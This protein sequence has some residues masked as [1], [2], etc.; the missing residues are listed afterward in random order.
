M[1]LL[2]LN[3]DLITLYS[4]RDWK[5]LREDK[6]FTRDRSKLFRIRYDRNF[7]MCDL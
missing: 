5:G 3:Y 7:S 2:R 1:I 6:Y 4:V